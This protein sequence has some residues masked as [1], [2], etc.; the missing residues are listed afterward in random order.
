MTPEERAALA[1]IGAQL[2][3]LAADGEPVAEVV[4]EPYEPP[5]AEEV[6]D[7]EEAYVAGQVAVIEA[8]AAADV[9]RTEAA[10][11]ADVARIEAQAD[12]RALEA[13][14]E[15][16]AAAEVVEAAGEAGAFDE[17]PETVVVADEQP[18]EEVAAEVVEQLA[19]EVADE[20]PAQP[21]V[22]PTE[23]HWFY[24]PLFARKG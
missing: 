3:A 4:A 18:A 10:A 1:A 15:G 24:R 14:A 20:A 17:T 23:T 19:T 8:E 5:P 2:V 22:R 6:A 9:A 11:A 12:A 7:R 16:E 13:F 21:D